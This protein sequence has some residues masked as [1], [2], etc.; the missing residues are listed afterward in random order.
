ML[1]V[2]SS[3]F[4]T[5]ASSS[6]NTI[7]QVC[8]QH[9]NES[10]RTNPGILSVFLCKSCHSAPSSVSPVAG[11]GGKFFLFECSSTLKCRRW[12][13][14]ASCKSRVDCRRMKQH[15]S[16]LKHTN[17][18]KCSSFL[19]QSINPMPICAAGPSHVPHDVCVGEKKQEPP[20][21][22]VCVPPQSSHEFDSCSLSSNSTSSDCFLGDLVIQEEVPSSALLSSFQI[23]RWIELLFEQVDTANHMSI[24]ESFG[25]FNDPFSAHANPT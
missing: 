8:L 7:P 10:D 12:Y 13:F 5:M 4:S 25:A 2:Y 22:E 3:S 20:P 15:F 21:S 17:K 14:C 23:P 1:H 16:S 18:M 11:F 24:M 19:N 6:R 9:L